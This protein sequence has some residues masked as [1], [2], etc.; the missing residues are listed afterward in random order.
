MTLPWYAHQIRTREGHCSKR[1]DVSTTYAWGGPGLG[2][3]DGGRD[4]N[5]DRSLL[6]GAVPGFWGESTGYQGTP[7]A[8]AKCIELLYKWYLRRNISAF[9][10]LESRFNLDIIC[11]TFCLFLFNLDARL[12]FTLGEWTCAHQ[13][14]FYT[15]TDEHI[16]KRQKDKNANMNPRLKLHIKR[17]HMCPSVS[18]F[19]ASFPL[20]RHRLGRSCLKFFWRTTVDHRGPGP[21]SRWNMVSDGGQYISKFPGSQSD[22]K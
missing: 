21:A 17:T 8:D 7:T 13:C 12:G 4:G 18:G 16:T 20:S 19:S 3:W 9:L 10:N 1:T 15:N 2:A 5:E 14:A 6:S 11:K 22:A